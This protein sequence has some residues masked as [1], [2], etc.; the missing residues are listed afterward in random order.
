MAQFENI[1]T[2]VV[3]PVAGV[4]L[5]AA[6]YA[7]FIDNPL[8]VGNKPVLPFCYTHWRVLPCPYD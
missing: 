1:F 5:A 8:E 3:T 6:F 4:A 2:R 7:L